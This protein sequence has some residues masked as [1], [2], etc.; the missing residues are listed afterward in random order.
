M[1]APV[2]I[3][4]SHDVQVLMSVSDIVLVQLG[5]DTGRAEDEGQHLQDVYPRAREIGK[6]TRWMFHSE[7]H[8]TETAELATEQ[9]KHKLLKAWSPFWDMT[10]PILLEK[11]PRHTLMMR[12]HQR[13]FGDESR[14]LMTIR[15]PFGAAY[16]FYHL[17]NKRRKREIAQ[18]FHDT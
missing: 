17:Y 14:F 3:R 7:A 6:A 13:V 18:R 4:G 12:F 11:S 1:Q 15:H 5:I 10:R 8:L 16:H 9:T 2:P